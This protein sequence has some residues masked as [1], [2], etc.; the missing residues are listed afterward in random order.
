[1]KKAVVLI[2]ALVLFCSTAFAQRKYVGW[3]TG[4]H[5]NWGTQQVANTNW[6]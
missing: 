4:Y 2:L 3:S 6:K 1:M 5:T